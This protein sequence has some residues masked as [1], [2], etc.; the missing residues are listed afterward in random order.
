MTT[1]TIFDGGFFKTRE[2][3]EIFGANPIREAAK[4]EPVE[5]E[6]CLVPTECETSGGTTLALPGTHYLA[7]VVGQ[8]PRKPRPVL[9]SVWND[10]YALSPENDGTWIPTG[11]RVVQVPEGVTCRLVTAEPDPADPTQSKVQIA[12]YPDF[13][14]V[15]ANGEVYHNGADDFVKKKLVPVDGRGPLD[16]RDVK[17]EAEV[18]EAC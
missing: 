7:F 6:D 9:K 12:E 17:K 15:G 3:I 16:I 14:A 11:R 8:N 4:K 2:G 1:V 18:T 10:Q 5:R 13:V